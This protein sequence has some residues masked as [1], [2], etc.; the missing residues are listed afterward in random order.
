MNLADALEYREDDET[1]KQAGE[2]LS[3]LQSL[4]AS[5]C[6]GPTLCSSSDADETH[7]CM[8]RTVLLKTPLSCRAWRSCLMPT[9]S[10]WQVGEAAGRSLGCNYPIAMT[11]CSYIGACNVRRSTTRKCFRFPILAGQAGQRNG[12]TVAPAAMIMRKLYA[13]GDQAERDAGQYSPVPAEEG[14]PSGSAQPGEDGGG[15]EDVYSL[16]SSEQDGGPAGALAAGSDSGPTEE[17]SNAAGDDAQTAAEGSLATYHAVIMVSGGT[18]KYS[19]DSSR[20]QSQSWKW[21]IHG[22]FASH[23]EQ[24]QKAL[25]AQ[26]GGSSGTGAGG[27]QQAPHADAPTQVAV[28]CNGV[29]GVFHIIKQVME[30]RCKACQAKV[31]AASPCLHFCAITV[32]CTGDVLLAAA[33]CTGPAHARG[34]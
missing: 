6:L 32:D 4:S 19:S 27:A 29:R 2:R 7:L 23:A 10:T 15:P 26:S 13:I 14:A 17:D 34:F 16:A 8:Q 1:D 12:R 25:A 24:Q 18:E 31:G 20:K 11:V 3:I 9:C 28:I 21:R 33:P 5:M 30:C 22:G